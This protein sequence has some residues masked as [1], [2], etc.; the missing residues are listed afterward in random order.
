[1]RLS[2]TSIERRIGTT[3]YFWLPTNEIIIIDPGSEFGK[4]HIYKKVKDVPCDNLHQILK[5]YLDNED[6]YN[7]NV[8]YVNE[9]GKDIKSQILQ[10]KK[11]GSE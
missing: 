8:L 9:I 1:L 7:P 4:I 3:T 6:L 5:E 11:E 2:Y 10:L